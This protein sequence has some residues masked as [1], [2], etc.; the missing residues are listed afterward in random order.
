MKRQLTKEEKEICN[1]QLNRLKGELE[2]Q[3]YLL[4]YTNLILNKGLRL[5][6]ER[7]LRNKKHNFKFQCI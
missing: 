3:N 6:Y 1:E 4:E 7:E 2:Y 5:N